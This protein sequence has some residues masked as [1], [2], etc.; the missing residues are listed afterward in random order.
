MFFPNLLHHVVLLLI[1]FKLISLFLNFIN[2]ESNHHVVTTT[3]VQNFSQMSNIWVRS[4]LYF[5]QTNACLK[6]TKETQEKGVKYVQWCLNFFF[7]TGVF[8]FFNTSILIFFNWCFCFFSG[9]FVLSFENILHLLK[10]F[11]C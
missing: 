3:V 2:P 4:I 5:Q 10:C 1:S 8:F 7:N 9:V 11:Y 6:S